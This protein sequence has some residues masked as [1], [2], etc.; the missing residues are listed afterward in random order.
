MRIGIDTHYVTTGAGTGNRRYTESLVRAL[1]RLDS[2]HDFVLY[3][4]AP[5]PFYAEFADHPHVRTRYVLPRAGWRRNYFTFP[6]VTR[7]DRLDV[8]HLHMLPPGVRVPCVLGIHDLYYLQAPSRSLYER[9]IN[10]AVMAG[11]PR[12]RE[13]V[14]LSEYSKRD[15]VTLCGASPEHVTAIPLAAGNRYRPVED[16][17]VLDT[18]RKK[19]GLAQD[20]VLFVGRVGDPRKNVVTLVEAYAKVRP[21][22]AESHQLVIAGRHNDGTELVRARIAELGLEE[23]VLLPGV[24]DEEDLPALLSGASVVVYVSSFEGFGLPVLEAMACGTP[25]ITA[26]TTSLP[27]V[28]GDAAVTITPGNLEELCAALSALL[29]DGARRAVLRDRSLRQAA[30]F[31]WARTAEETLRVYERAAS[32][33]V[34]GVKTR[35]G[36]VRS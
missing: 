11:V 16:E 19:L 5:D 2:G 27:E 9:G 8:V 4:I 28:A 18:L 13:V 26:N 15:I 3:A 25:V 12:A 20:Y 33:A 10:R 31:S 23:H 1:I 6:R 34:G 17:R 21:R 36:A 24:V 29:S 35:G 7:Q 32:G 22:N 14:T 30:R